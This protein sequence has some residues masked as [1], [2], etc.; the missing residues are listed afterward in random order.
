M[1][2]LIKQLKEKLESNNEFGP[3]AEILFINLEF[4]LTCMN[5]AME[6]VKSQGQQVNVTKDPDKDPHWRKNLWKNYYDENLDK[7]IRLLKAL[8]LTP[9]QCVWAILWYLFHKPF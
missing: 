6:N 3:E 9:E 8:H 1:E 2:D 4:I 7:M 5:E